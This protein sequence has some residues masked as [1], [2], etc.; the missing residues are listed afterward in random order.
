MDFSLFDEA[1]RD[2]DAEAATRR[3]ALVRT[4]VVGEIFPF[5]ADAESPTE[6]RHR[7]ALASERLMSIA[8]RHDA[9]PAEVE[10]IADRMFARLLES[11]QAAAKTRCGA[12]G[13]VGKDHA[14]GLKCP[15]CGCTNYTPQTTSA[16]TEARQVTAE[17]EGEG[18]FS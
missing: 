9:S 11:R 8:E 10:D 14:E 16:R 12:C 13:H 15:K 7:K 2:Y 18:P 5:L 3:T 6:Y 4:A 1:A 17:S